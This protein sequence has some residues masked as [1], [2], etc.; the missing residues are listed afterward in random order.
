MNALG[1]SSLS[2]MCEFAQITKGITQIQDDRISN[3]TRWVSEVREAG[4]IRNFEMENLAMNINGTTVQYR[5]KY[6]D[7]N[8]TAFRDSPWEAVI[9]SSCLRYNVNREFGDREENNFTQVHHNDKSLSIPILW[10]NFP[11]TR[12]RDAGG[13]TT[14]PDLFLWR[15]TVKPSLSLPWRW[16][17]K[18]L[19]FLRSEEHTYTN[20]SF[21]GTTYT[22]HVSE[23]ETWS[24]DSVPRGGLHVLCR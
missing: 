21:G 3:A 23:E 13:N 19:E 22:G 15:Q 12:H 5:Y 6:Q 20:N 9:E 2:P 4:N 1:N 10:S 24:L 16:V 17:M 8:S 7:L 14:D 18:T 11:N